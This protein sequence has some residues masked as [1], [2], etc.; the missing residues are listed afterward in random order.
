MFPLVET[1]HVLGLAVSVG[2]ILMTDLRLVGG[3]MREE[4]VSDVMVQL[5][6]WMWTGF[7]LMFVSG[8]LLF[9]S[10]AAKCYAST[11]FRIK[12]LFLFLAGLNAFVFEST[13]GRRMLAWN[14]VAKPPAR[15]RFA[16]WASLVC[17][18]AVILFGRWTAYRM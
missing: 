16:G 1:V 11:T 3:F 9:W 13:I 7:G 5:R 17:W 15:A 18:T 4:P 6:R 12:I 2:L 8:G 10:E 14:Q